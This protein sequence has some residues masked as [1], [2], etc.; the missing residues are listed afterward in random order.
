M[1]IEFH[2][3]LCELQ[4]FSFTRNESMSVEQKW[5]EHVLRREDKPP[6]L[7]LT[8]QQMPRCQAGDLG[9]VGFTQLT[10]AANNISIFAGIAVS[11][12]SKLQKSRKWRLNALRRR[13]CS[14]CCYWRGRRGDGDGSFGT[15]QRGRSSDLSRN[16]P[17]FR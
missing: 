2:L 16:R 7:Q 5:M 11:F 10:C 12:G 4:K 8:N 3:V 1:P 13:R 14:L 9:K 6:T 17:R 15:G